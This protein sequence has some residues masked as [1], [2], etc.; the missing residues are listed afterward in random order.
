MRASCFTVCSASR[1]HSLS[2]WTS[3]KTGSGVLVKSH[4]RFNW[5]WSGFA[6]FWLQCCWWSCNFGLHM[7]NTVRCEADMKAWMI[8]INMSIP[9]CLN[10]LPGV[11]QVRLSNT[12]ML[13]ILNMVFQI[14]K[15]SLLVTFLCFYLLL[16]WIWQVALLLWKYSL[17][18]IL[19]CCQHQR[20]FS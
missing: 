10:A 7:F 4:L 12:W 6:V 2:P 19:V 8:S 20:W 1:R 17:F 15:C 5:L 11:K 3:G 16:L 13:D 14:L 9:R 18:P